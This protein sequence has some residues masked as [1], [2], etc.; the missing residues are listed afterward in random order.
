LEAR[1]V[2]DLSPGERLILMETIDK[3]NDSLGFPE[4]EDN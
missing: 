4:Q 3:I 2:A 1:L